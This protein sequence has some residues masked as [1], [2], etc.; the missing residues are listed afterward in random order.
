MP[1][2]TDILCATNGVRLAS[3]L[4][5]SRYLYRLD[6]GVELPF[7]TDYAWC[8][9]CERFVECERLYSVDEIQRHIDDL[10]AT[11]ATWGEEDAHLSDKYA[12]LG[13][14]L[15][16]GLEREACYKRWV[17][18]LGWRQERKSPPRCLECGSFF[19][20]KVLPDSGEFPHPAGNG[21][22]ILAC[23]GHACVAGFPDFVIFNAEGVKVDQ[24]PFDEYR[25]KQ[26]RS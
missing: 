15:P 18:A 19:A 6:D 25:G 12:Q 23:G 3:F 21:T 24:V 17:A 10:I 7:T 1:Y 22:V 11:K 8:H 4:N 16:N 2:I 5:W 14:S 13:I 9:R 26:G 20:I